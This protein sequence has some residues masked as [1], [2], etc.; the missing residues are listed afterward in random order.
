DF[1]TARGAEAAGI[2]AHSRL[3]QRAYDRNYIVPVPP[4]SPR[5]KVV[6]NSQALDFYWDDS[7][8]QAIDPTSPVPHDFE[9]YR[10]YLGEDRTD[11]RRVAQFDKAT[12][13]NDTT[14]FNTGLDA[15]GRSQ[16]VWI[17]GVRH[18]CTHTIASL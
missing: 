3:A 9:G 4:P 11:L 5:F 1:P 16:P 10:L 17:D 2:Q 7:P 12:P 6:A 14:G 18:T 8:E 15:V 13:P